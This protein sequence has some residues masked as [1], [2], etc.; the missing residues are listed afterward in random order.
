MTR[1]VYIA[2]PL[3]SWC[4]GFGPELG[5]LLAR[6]REARLELLMGGLRA[7]NTEPMSE[8]FRAMLRGHWEHVA[9]ASGQPFS[10]AIFEHAGFV[11]DTEPPCR[12][13]VTARAID[14]A[15]AFAFMKA[16]QSAFY[17]DGRDVTRPDVLA[18]IAS[19]CGYERAAFL[20]NLESQAM[21]DATRSDFATAQSLGVSGFP[22]LAL[23]HA[24]QLYL[25][26]SGFVTDDVLEHRVTEIERRLGEGSAATAAND[27]H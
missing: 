6:R 24:S 20:A 11:Y 3:C 15:R 7:F 2:D 18:E 10:E 26:T 5:K 8:P 25:V 12:A 27:A 22:T 4:Y 14:S 13:V 21:R 17:R 23:A 1:L 16:V 9:K 19:E